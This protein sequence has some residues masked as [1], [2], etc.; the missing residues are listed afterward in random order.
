MYSP[1]A[2]LKMFFFRSIILRTPFCHKQKTGQIREWERDLNCCVSLH[3]IKIM[4]HIW[5]SIVP[6]LQVNIFKWKSC[7]FL[8]KSSLKTNN[9]PKATTCRKNKKPPFCSPLLLKS[10]SLYVVRFNFTQK[11]QFPPPHIKTDPTFPLNPQYF[12]KPAISCWRFTFSWQINELLDV[13]TKLNMQE[14]KH[15][16]VSLILLN[17]RTSR[18]PLHSCQAV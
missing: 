2:S 13:F 8:G 17:G 18:N 14:N 9:T 10:Q 12:Q 15:L 5:E 6:E 16:K 1:W 3:L 4:V 11:K 7:W